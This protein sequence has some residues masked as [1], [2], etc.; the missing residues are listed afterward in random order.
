VRWR[1]WILVV[2][3]LA[4]IIGIGVAPGLVIDRFGEGVFPAAELRQ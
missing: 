4:L 2:P 3:L 1:E